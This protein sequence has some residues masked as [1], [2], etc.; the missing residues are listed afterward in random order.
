MPPRLKPE[1]SIVAGALTF[2]IAVGYTAS[3]STQSIA[4]LTDIENSTRVGYFEL[5][6]N[7]VNFIT[8]V[9]GDT[10]TVRRIVDDVNLLLNLKALISE[11]SGREPTTGEKPV[12]DST[13]SFVWG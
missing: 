6:D 10:L 1:L 13:G 11:N 8:V 2:Q 3:I 12:I 4:T 7:D 9:D 5:N